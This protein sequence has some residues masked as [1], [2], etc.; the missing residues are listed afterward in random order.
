LTLT[1]SE[2]FSRRNTNRG[3]EETLAQM[4]DWIA[5]YR[6]AGIEP[7]TLGLMAVFG[8][9]YEGEIPQASSAP[10]RADCSDF[11]RP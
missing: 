9:N 11:G 2:T 8:C 5:R 6:V 4:P 1:A 10:D 3:I 7:N